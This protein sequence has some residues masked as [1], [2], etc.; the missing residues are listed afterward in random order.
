MKKRIFL[1]FTVL[2][3]LVPGLAALADMPS[4]KPQALWKYITETSPYTT[5]AFWPDHQGMQPGRSPHGSFHKVFV[6][7]NGLNSTSPPVQYG[8]IAVKENYSFN[9]ELQ[10]ITVM[11][12]V[13]GYRPDA[14][15]W[16]WVKYSPDGKTE[17]LSNEKGCIGCHSTRWKNDFI[18]V[19]E[20]K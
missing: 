1:F 11:Y 20:F 2:F 19:H 7:E 18:L 15:D 12:K 4:A 9:K 8:T 6:N 3:F 10:A 17:R 16:Y 5:W 14:G 13:K